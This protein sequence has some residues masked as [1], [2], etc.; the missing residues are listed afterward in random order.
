MPCT[1]TMQSTT[2]CAFARISA[3]IYALRAPLYLSVPCGMVG[4]WQTNSGRASNGVT[5]KYILFCWLMASCLLKTRGCVTS[6]ILIQLSLIPEKNIAGFETLRQAPSALHVNWT[7]SAFKIIQA[8]RSK[9]NQ[10]GN[11]IAA[12]R[13][14]RCPCNSAAQ[15]LPKGQ[16]CRCQCTNSSQKNGS[17][18]RIRSFATDGE[19]TLSGFFNNSICLAGGGWRW[20]RRGGLGRTLLHHDDKCRRYSVLQRSRSLLV[21]QTTFGSLINK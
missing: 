3:H 1:L 6:D 13:P 7:L 21:Y 15:G 9:Q 17:T 2:F 10:I 8:G 16:C 4:R 18:S 19:D 5:G 11:F 14:C 12:G 20:T